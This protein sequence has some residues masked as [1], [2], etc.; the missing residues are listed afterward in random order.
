M[1]ELEKLEQIAQSEIIVIPIIDV[2]GSMAGEKIA[3]VLEK[4]HLL[5]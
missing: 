1:S 3:K 5:R 4:L 2:S